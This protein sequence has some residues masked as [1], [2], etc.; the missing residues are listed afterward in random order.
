MRKQNK[1]LTYL[2]G[3]AV[4]VI[5]AVSFVKVGEVRH[6]AW[7]MS[8]TQTALEQYVPEHPADLEARV[9]LGLMEVADKDPR[10]EERLKRAADAAP[11]DESVWFAYVDAIDNPDVALSQI[12]TYLKVLPNSVKLRA[13]KARRLAELG[14]PRTGLAMAD[15]IIKV[16]GK[17]SDA[18]RA[19]ADALMLLRRVNE[20]S[21]SLKLAMKLDDRDSYRLLLAM[22]L[23][24]QQRYAEVREACLPIVHRQN[25][26]AATGHVT[27]AKLYLAGATLN[28]AAPMKE[29]ANVKSD[30]EAIVLNSTCVEEA[31]QFLP[32]YFLGECFLQLGEPQSAIEPLRQAV[33]MAPQFP[34]ALY[35]LARAMQASKEN[36]VSSKLYRRHANL[37]GLL[38][39]LD[40]AGIRLQERP[41]DVR[42]NQQLA[43]IQKRL[44][45]LL[46]EPLPLE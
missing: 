13:A 33:K 30:L 15:E 1:R 3:V 34:A 24:P 35:S 23:V 45:N 39:D 20:A 21:D 36:S 27:R 4:F 18:F 2:V 42:L 8:A 46:R 26:G 12:E 31:E 43:D 32:Y 9:R 5:F 25:R 7:L 6:R 40:N 37:T 11:G 22:T 14:D 10:G 28:L 41:D 44:E 29:L 19:R 17:D 38:N 16:S